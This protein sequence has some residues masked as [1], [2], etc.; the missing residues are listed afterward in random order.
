MSEWFKEHAWKACERATVPEVRILS[1]PPLK[2]KNMPS[3]CEVYFYILIYLNCE[4]VRTDAEGKVRNVG[5]AVARKEACL[6]SG[7]YE[8]RS[9]G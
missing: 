3:E 8:L 6:L 1:L 5:V 9:R 7:C 2:Y 4:R